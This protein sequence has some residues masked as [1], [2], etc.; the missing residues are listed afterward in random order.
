[1]ESISKAS[2]KKRLLNFII[3]FCTIYLL[4]QLWV[5]LILSIEGLNLKTLLLLSLLPHPIYYFLFE[6]L[7][8]RTLGKFITRTKVVSFDG[9]KPTLRSVLIRTIGRYIPFEVF[10]FVGSR[11]PSGWHDTLSNT[12]VV[13]TNLYTSVEIEKEAVKP[14]GK[15]SDTSMHSS[16]VRSRKRKVF[17]PLLIIF[18]TTIFIILCLIAIKLMGYEVNKDYFSYSKESC[19]A[20]INQKDIEHELY[21]K[22]WDYLSEKNKYLENFKPDYGYCQSRYKGFKDSCFDM[23]IEFVYDESLQKMVVPSSLCH[24]DRKCSS[25]LYIDEKQNENIA[26]LTSETKDEFYWEFVNNKCPTQHLLK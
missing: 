16:M 21:W 20:N 10:S 23:A 1:M 4:S 14:T 19:I 5:D 8:Q 12:A 18:G 6:L 2:W 26:Y 17:L 24:E 11:N 15:D 13:N 9:R 25:S 22:R 7:T 3:D